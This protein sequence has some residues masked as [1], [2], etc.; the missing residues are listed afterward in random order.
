ML[1]VLWLVLAAVRVPQTVLPLIL[2]F[3]LLQRSWRSRLTADAV[4]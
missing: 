1:P 2:A 4:K 3:A